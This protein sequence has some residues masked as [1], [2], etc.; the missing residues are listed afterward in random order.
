MLTAVSETSNDIKSDSIKEVKKKQ[1]VH[2]MAVK[3]KV[4]SVYSIAKWKMDFSRASFP[5]LSFESETRKI[6]VF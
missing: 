2:Q 6:L 4:T 5:A 1:R 3:S